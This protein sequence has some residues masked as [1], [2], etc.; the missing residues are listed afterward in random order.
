LRGNASVGEAERALGMRV[1]PC[2]SLH[3]SRITGKVRSS[4]SLRPRR[5]GPVSAC[6]RRSSATWRQIAFFPRSQHQVSSSLQR[7]ILPD[8]H[9][10]HLLL[11]AHLMAYE[12]DP[13]QANIRRI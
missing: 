7:R 12:A 11:P 6:P 8:R 13:R 10:I 9:V 1:L 5:K 3:R 2:W 4:P